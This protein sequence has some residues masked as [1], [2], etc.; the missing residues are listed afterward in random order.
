MKGTLNKRNLE[1]TCSHISLIQANLRKTKSKSGKAAKR[2]LWVV[3]NCGF[4]TAHRSTQEPYSQFFFYAKKNPSGLHKKF[5]VFPS[6]CPVC[7][8]YYHY[9]NQREGRGRGREVEVEE[10]VSRL[11]VNRP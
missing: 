1:K 5:N 3:G 10:G 4:K 8:L 11:C 6:A 2:A 9:R 7:L